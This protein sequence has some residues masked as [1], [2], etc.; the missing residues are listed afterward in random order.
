MSSWYTENYLNLN[1]KKPE[2]ELITDFRKKKTTQHIGL[3]IK[4]EEVEQGD[5][6][7]FQG[8]YIS[9]DLSWRMNTAHLI[10]KARQCVSLRTL[11]HINYYQTC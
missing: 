6:F 4:G 1:T 2:K 10:K 5:K 9:E 8:I 7:K 11:R 3:S